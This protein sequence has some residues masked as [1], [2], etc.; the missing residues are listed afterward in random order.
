VNVGKTSSAIFAEMMT[1]P[2]ARAE[3]IDKKK[4]L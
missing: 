1:E 3:N 4:G 2:P